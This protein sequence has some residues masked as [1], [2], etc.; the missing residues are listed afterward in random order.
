ML[1]RKSKVLIFY[2]CS[3]E[4]IKLEGL[5]GFTGR[6]VY[7][8]SITNL[9]H[10]I[11]TPELAPKIHSLS[12]V[13]QQNADKPVVSQKWNPTIASAYC[14]LYACLRF[15]ISRDKLAFLQN[16]QLRRRR[17]RDLI[18]TKFAS[19]T[20]LCTTILKLIS[21]QVLWDILRNLSQIL[22][23]SAPLLYGGRTH[24]SDTER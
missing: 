24:H 1:W 3:I 18:A 20:P 14:G 13:L 12:D 10:R 21:P 6:N 23:R 22:F 11:Y 7:H 5:G 16:C 8:E 9:L 2:E 19:Q 4:G 17:R 15:T